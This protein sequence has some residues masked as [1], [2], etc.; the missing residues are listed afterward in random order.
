M[1]V[2]RIIARMNVGGPARQVAALSGALDGNRF[3]QRLLVGSVGPH[4]ADF[5]LSRTLPVEV[6]TLQGLGRAVRPF[7]DVRAFAALVREIRRFHPAIVHTHT[8]K[9]GFLG[10][11]AAIVAYP[12]RRR[13]PRLVHTFHGHLLHGYFRPTTT[14]AVVVIERLLAARTDALF[15][16]GARVRDELLQVGIGQ[17]EQYTVM[18]PGIVVEATPDREHAREAFCLPPNRPVVLFVGRLARVKRPD[19]FVELADALRRRVPDA[20]FLVL[21]GGEL[22]SSVRAQVDRF[23]LRDQVRFEGWREDIMTAYAAADVL[24]LTSDNEGM[25]VTLIEAALAGTPAVTTNVGSAGEVVVDGKT[26]FVV[27]AD[28][29]SIADAVAQLL[30]DPERRASFGAEARVLARE[31]FSAARLARDT[32][33]VYEELVAGGPC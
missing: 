10:R 25:P 9:A 21:G 3:R 32:A 18:P 1:R 5:L 7:D 6:V 14:R 22:E 28:V 2:L 27:P 26:G 29:T 30:L 8:A 33:A 23:G 15:A 24:V 12:R 16:V 4:E 11:A 17:R 19:R 13:R 20:L 31:R